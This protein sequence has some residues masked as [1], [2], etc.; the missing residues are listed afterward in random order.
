MMFYFR[1]ETEFASQEI[2]VNGDPF[3]QNDYKQDRYDDWF[4]PVPSTTNCI[5]YVEVLPEGY[6]IVVLQG[7]QDRSFYL[8]E[9]FGEPF[10]IMM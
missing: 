9:C 2:A 7:F 1:N 4:W 8:E 5:V 3:F 6:C 10:D